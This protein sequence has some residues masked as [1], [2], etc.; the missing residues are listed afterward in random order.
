MSKNTRTYTDHDWVAWWFCAGC[1]KHSFKNRKDCKDQA[2]RIFPDKKMRLYK[3][4]DTGEWHMTSYGSLKAEA[5]R[6]YESKRS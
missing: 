1:G 2:K 4:K 3:C 5:W 6:E